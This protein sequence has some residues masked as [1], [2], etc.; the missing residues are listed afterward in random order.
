MRRVR[1]RSLDVSLLRRFHLPRKKNLSDL[2]AS[3]MCH[4]GALMDKGE[5]GANDT[6]TATC[7]HPRLTKAVAGPPNGG[8]R[9][10]VPEESE[11]F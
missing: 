7:S 6:A 9:R 3:E 5:H 2:V 4:E 1:A 11:I 10:H 8:E